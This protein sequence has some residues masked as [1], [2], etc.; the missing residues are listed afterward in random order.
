MSLRLSVFSTLGITLLLSSAMAACG[1]GGDDDG[2]D[3]SA[4]CDEA[5]QHS[6]LA[7][8]QDNIFSQSCTIS[9]SCHRGDATSAQGLSLEPGVAEENLVGQPAQGDN[10]AGLNLVEPGNP[11]QSYIMVVLGEFG[12]DD[13]RLS[14]QGLMPPNSAFNCRE[15][16]R[17]AI[18]RWIDSL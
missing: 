17:G 7:W 1:G 8:I 4:A 5:T 3:D 6:D 18:G 15:E 10:A 9:G 12:E 14:D 2:G 11:D 16:K 13:P